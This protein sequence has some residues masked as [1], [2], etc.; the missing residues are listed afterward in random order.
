MAHPKIV[1]RGRKIILLS[2]Y[3][4]RTRGNAEEGSD[5]RRGFVVDAEDKLSQAALRDPEAVAFG[6]VHGEWHAAA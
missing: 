5:A 3:N 4:D 1:L 6:Y 2:G